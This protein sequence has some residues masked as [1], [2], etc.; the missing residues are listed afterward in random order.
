MIN[1]LYFL[2]V[3]F[4]FCS[5]FAAPPENGGG[6]K[7]KKPLISMDARVAELADALDLGSS[8]QP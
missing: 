3:E 7:P 6:K 8:G 5:K 2:Y 1:V 4:Y